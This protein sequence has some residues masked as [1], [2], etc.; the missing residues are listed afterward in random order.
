MNIADD[1]HPEDPLPASPHLRWTRD[2][3]QPP[4]MGS[5]D[6]NTCVY[7][8]DEGLRCVTWKTGGLNGSLT[9][10]QLSREQKQNYF[11]RLIENNNI[12]CL[13]EVHEKDEFLQAIQ[14]LAPRFWLYGTFIPGNANAGGSVT[15][16][17]EDLL[18]DDAV[19]THVITCQGRDHIVNV[20]SGS[21]SPV[22]VNVHFEPEL[23]LRS[24]RERRCLITPHWPQCPNAIGTRGRKIQCLESNIHRL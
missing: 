22:V 12:I 14:V 7:I 5:L 6:W 23:T 20:R 4:H 8:P 13:Q 10:S 2:A 1:E 24:L 17:H 21:R 15:C 11:R 3:L 16:I 18:P 9:S 19:V